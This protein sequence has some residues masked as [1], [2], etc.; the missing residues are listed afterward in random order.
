MPPT[1]QPIDRDALVAWYTRTRARSRQIFDLVAGSAYYARPIQLRHPVVFY[2][3]HLPVFSVNTLLKKGLGHPG[4]DLAFETLFARG[5]DPDDEVEAA[6]RGAAAWPTRA[7]VR[8]YA[9]EADAAILGA[10]A[11]GPIVDDRVPVLKAAEAAFAIIEH[12]AMHHETLLYMWHRLPL[13]QKHPPH[14]YAPTLGGAAPE[15][16]RVSVPAGEATLGTSLAQAPFAWDNERDP[17]RV[18]VEAFEVDAFN[19]TN[20]D[21]ERFVDAGGYRDPQ[22]WRPED[23]AWVHANELAHPIFW[24]RHGGAWHWRGMFHLVPLPPS[25]PVYV[26]YAEACAYARWKNAR[27][28]TEAE[29]HRAACGT[30]DGDEQPFPWGSAP[31]SPAHGV[32]DFESW[33]PQPV[34]SR[35]RG[36]S[37]W[38]VHDL[39]GNGW[40]W[41]STVFGPFDG[42]TPLPSYPEY[43]ADFFDGQH[44]VMKGASPVTSRDLIRRGFRNWFRPH[45]PYMYASFRC[46]Y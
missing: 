33:D 22:W 8:R 42:F 44:Y 5:I 28:M 6:A 13:E 18:R 4:I 43:S 17:H 35:P 9:E 45:Y 38:G 12:E 20:A 34:G 21:F 1:A 46:A 19:V 29:Y 26:T 40:E 37:A 25:W 27:L 16:R 30:P 3:G 41:T 10:L 32:F 14:G 31:P 39:M 2:E 23:W 11:H 24:E 36:V 15:A 7:E